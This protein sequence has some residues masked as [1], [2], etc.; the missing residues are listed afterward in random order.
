MATFV[1]NHRI[2]DCKNQQGPQRLSGLT[3]SF[4]KQ[5]NQSPL[6]KDLAVIDDFNDTC[7]PELGENQGQDPH[8][9]RKSR[10]PG[11]SFN[12]ILIF[13]SSLKEI[14]TIEGQSHTDPGVCL[15]HPLSDSV[16]LEKSLYISISALVNLEKSKVGPVSWVVVRMTQASICKALSTGQ[17]LIKCM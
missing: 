13:P 15:A 4:Y 17:E 6:V 8:R 11:R 14:R 2:T 7:S 16:T 3:F 9:A 1:W 10:T 12:F 5:G